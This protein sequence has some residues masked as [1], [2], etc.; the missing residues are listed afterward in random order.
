MW[1]A[2]REVGREEGRQDQKRHVDCRRLRGQ[3]GREE[4]R[5]VHKRHVEGREGGRKGKGEAEGPK[6]TCGRQRKR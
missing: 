1:K 5:Q 4:G 2:E 3:Q 6:E